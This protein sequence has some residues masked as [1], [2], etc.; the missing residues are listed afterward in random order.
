MNN[1]NYLLQD[2]GTITAT[3]AADFVTK[4]REGV[5]LIQNVPIRNICSTLP[6]DI[7]TKQETLFVLIL[8]R[9]LLKI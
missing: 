6:T 9:I 1:R 4:L 7:A 2:G 3:C 5:V 8:R